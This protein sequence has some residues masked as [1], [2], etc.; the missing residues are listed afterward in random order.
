MI[1]TLIDILTAVLLLLGAAF[2]LIGSIGLASALATQRF[3]STRRALG[4]RRAVAVVPV[5]EE[6]LAGHAFLALL[7]QQF[8]NLG[9]LGER[10]PGKDLVEQH[11]HAMLRGRR[12]DGGKEAGRRL[13]QTGASPVGGPFP[14]PPL[15]I[16]SA[17][18]ERSPLWPI[19]R[20]PRTRSSA[21]P[22]PRP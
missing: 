5:V 16:G 4:S 8:R 21:S 10:Q 7:G 19:S 6:L 9:D 14:C 18:K 1:A 3:L 12:P 20:T 22:A 11:H 2:A 13:A 17:A 15:R